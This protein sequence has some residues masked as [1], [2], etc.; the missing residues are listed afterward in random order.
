MPE[1]LT[2]NSDCYITGTPTQAL[3]PA[4]YQITPTHPKYHYYGGSATLNLKIYPSVHAD[5]I[6]KY[7]NNT[8]WKITKPGEL[9]EDV[10]GLKISHTDDT[11]KTCYSYSSVWYL[12][13]RTPMTFRYKE[14]DE[15]IIQ[16]HA[17][18]GS[19]G[20]GNMD[21]EYNISTKELIEQDDGS[22]YQVTNKIGSCN[23]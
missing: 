19:S 13:A 9:A 10:K 7:F 11:Y 12:K 23:I 4:A 14:F 18:G 21:A 8:L 6:N 15:N 16:I 20:L 5:I 22:V 1:G 17:V 3:K 2:L